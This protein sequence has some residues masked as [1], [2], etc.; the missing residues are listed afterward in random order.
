MPGDDHKIRP[1][2]DAHGV[3]GFY[4]KFGATYSNPH[5]PHLKLLLE[6][7]IPARNLDL[8]SVLDL[9]CGS[10]EVSSVILRHGGSVTGIDPFTFEAYRN[11][12][13]LE[14]ERFSFEDIANGVLEGRRFSLIVCSFALHLVEVS[15]LPMVAFQLAQVG[16]TLLVLTPHKRP[17]LKVEWGWKL[18]AE[19]L[20]A[21][22]R[23]RLYRTSNPARL[24]RN[25]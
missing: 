18:E 20:E 15:R 22:V 4:E 12:T 23:A 6:T 24:Y 14:A 7:L 8:S 25:A 21:R 1:Q 5:E 2:Y 10:G 11:R 19:L 17:N 9:A 16:G 13:G 3:A